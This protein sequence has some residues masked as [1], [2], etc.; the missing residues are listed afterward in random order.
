M[1]RGA[2]SLMTKRLFAPIILILVS[3]MLL[4]HQASAYVSPCCEYAVYSTDVQPK[5]GE[6]VDL[7]GVVTD[8]FGGGQAGVQIIY[9]DA[10]NYENTSLNATTDV[11]GAWHLSV[12]MPQVN[13]QYPMKFMIAMNDSAERWTTSLT[14][15]YSYVSSSGDVP[16]V[17]ESEFSGRLNA[18]INLQ[19]VGFPLVI[20]LSGGYDQPI[21][22]GDSQ[23]D[24]STTNFLAAIAGAGY[25]V[26]A[27]IGWFVESVPIFPYVLAALAKFGMGIRRVFL[28]GWSAGGTASA[29]TL[30][31]DN[32]HLFDL[33][34]IMDAELQG[35]VASTQTDPSVFKTAQLSSQVKAPHLLIWGIGDSGSINIQSALT[36]TRNAPNGLARLDPFQYTH[37]WIGTPVESQ[38]QEDILGFFKTGSVGTFNLLQSGNVTLQFLTNSQINPVNTKFNQTRKLFQIQVTQPN[39]TIGSLNAVLPIASMDGAPVVLLDNLTVNAVSLSDGNNYRIYITYSGGNHS[40]LIRGQNSVPEFTDQIGRQIVFVGS[41][42][43]LL[44]LSYMSKCKHLAPSSQKKT[45]S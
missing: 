17:Y 10:G 4:P 21:L 43:S 18:Y 20:F 26:I 27:P 33:A 3:L 42:L 14:D 1:R 40:I 15:S 36:W 22:T 35:S 38:I 25:N 44:I 9:N 12:S 37:V 29:W 6:R 19:S 5:A 16:A 41:I 45:D 24:Q 28:L 30:V 31:N 7:T 23:L 39:G 11:N 32:Y 8:R 13:I 2:T 34:V